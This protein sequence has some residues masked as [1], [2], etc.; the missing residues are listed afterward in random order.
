VVTVQAFFYRY[1]KLTT[2]SD[3]ECASFSC[4][5]AS[6]KTC[7]SCK[8]LE[9]H[10]ELLKDMVNSLVDDNNGLRE[11]IRQLEEKAN[12]DSSNS[13]KPPSSDFP[14]KK[15]RTKKPKSKRK[16]GAQPGHANQQR[17]LLPRDQVD[18]FVSCK[19]ER[20]ERCTKPLSGADPDP[21]RVQHV[22]IPPIKPRVTEY[23]I[24]SL[25]CSCGHC[26]TG[27][28]PDDAWPGTFGPR[29]QAIVALLSGAYR[30]SKREIERILSDVFQVD[31]SLGSVCNLEHATSEALAEPVEEAKHHIQDQAVAF[32]DETGW[33]EDKRRAWLWC[34]VTTHM[35]VFLIRF[36]RGAKIARELLGAFSGILHSDRWAGYN[37]YDLNR[38]QLCWA[39]YLEHKIIQSPVVNK[40]RIHGTVW[41]VSCCPVGSE[42]LIKLLRLDGFVRLVGHEVPSEISRSARPASC[43]CAADM[44]RQRDEAR[45]GASLLSMGSHVPGRLHSPDLIRFL[46]SL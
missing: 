40:N 7:P 3:T 5:D 21:R 12:Q 20:C 39:H 29:I 25:S 36:S 33:R 32:V 43:G 42:L 31:L 4:M 37:W 34:A 38:R 9:K 2:L 11:R 14:P 6:D 1:P 46:E 45:H 17:K 19:P 10:V 28:L 41:S 24:H 30:L 8:R 13:S 22:E 35:T 26:T 16:R 23:Q 27:T 44:A 18:Q 15:R